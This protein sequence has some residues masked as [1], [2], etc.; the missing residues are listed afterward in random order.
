MVVVVL[1]VV[2]RL[3]ELLEKTGFTLAALE[4]G[5]DALPE[6]VRETANSETN[7]QGDRASTG[8]PLWQVHAVSDGKTERVETSNLARTDGM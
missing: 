6:A 7:C 3:A 1:V 8:V 5:C 2:V 4:G